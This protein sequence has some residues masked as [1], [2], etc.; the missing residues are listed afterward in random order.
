[1][2]VLQR[3]IENLALCCGELPQRSAVGHGVAG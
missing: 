2:V 3:E 1:V